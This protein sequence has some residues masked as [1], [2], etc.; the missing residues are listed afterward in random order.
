MDPYPSRGLAG[1]PGAAVRN[2]GEVW[3]VVGVRTIRPIWLAR[4]HARAVSTPRMQSLAV[5]TIAALGVVWT[6]STW[7]GGDVPSQADQ[8]RQAF[9]GALAAREKGDL[10]AAA[11]GLE[12]ATL[13]VPEWGLAHLE[14][15]VTRLELDP[16]DAGGVRSLER[17]IELEPQNPRAHLSLGLAYDRAGRLEEATR[18]LRAALERRPDLVDAKYALAGVTAQSGDDAGAIQLYREVLLARPGDV[19]SYAGLAELYEKGGDLPAAESALVAIVRQLPS[20]VYH[21]YRLA[22]FYERTGRHDRAQQV[23]GE[24]ESLDPRQRKMRK[25]R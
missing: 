12:R 19:G 22:E 1:K 14:L 18:E 9:D 25:L 3:D 17:A 2:T 15:G 20:V 6:A 8:A 21:R 5:T 10:A 7:P 4:P 24:I 16:Q 11:R 13:L 23:F